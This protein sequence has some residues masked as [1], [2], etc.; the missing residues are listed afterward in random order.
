MLTIL[1][2]V[3]LLVMLGVRIWLSTR[4][5]RHVLAHRDV[6]PKEFAAKIGL[7][8]HQRA[9]DYTVAKVRLRMLE[10]LFDAAVLIGLTLL[11]GL[12]Y[13]DTLT[14]SVTSH[15]LLRQVLLVLSVFLFLGV[16]GIP[17]TLYRQFKL[18]AHFGFNRMTL[19]MFV[20]DTIKETLVGALLG[21]PLIAAVL[22]LMSEAGN[23]WWLWAWALWSAFSLLLAFIYPTWIAPVFNKFTPLEDAALAQRIQ[24]LAG[25]CGFTLS[26]LF[27]MDGSKRSAHGNAYFTGF[28]RARRIVFFDTLLARLTP[29][30]IIAVLAHELGHFKHRHILKRMITMFIGSLIFFA[31]LGWLATQSW[32]YTDLGVIPQMG[33]RNDAMALLL[34]FLVVPIFTFGLT[35]LKSWL[36]R[37]DEFEADRFARDQS[38]ADEL[39][40]A[41]V[42]LMDDNASTLTPD[43]VHSAFY[44]SHPPA[45][46][47]IRQLTAA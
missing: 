20:S 8:S 1:F 37:R 33:T 12:Q 40:N 25:R 19:K 16:L 28:G 30:E 24:E 43:P 38:S 26:G 5:I 2:V 15:A 18:E 4:Q 14:S 17:F 22:W 36:S 23:L 27:V 31:L 3:L 32:F 6:V 45:A 13:L 11:G 21:I 10:M 34:F 7:P 29:N 44:D 9:A 46:I 42:K 47:R 39:I 41:L 35:P